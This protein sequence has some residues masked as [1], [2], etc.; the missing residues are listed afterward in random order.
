MAKK[1]PAKKAKLQLVVGSKIKEAINGKGC[2]M[3]GDTLAAV[4]D[5]VAALV[6]AGVER[7]KANKRSTV[8][9]QDL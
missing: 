8:R 9:P 5:K 7:A 1:A 2:K 6:A 3:S 4:N